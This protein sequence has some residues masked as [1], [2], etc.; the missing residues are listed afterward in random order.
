MKT[1]QMADFRGYLLLVP[2]AGGTT[3][4]TTLTL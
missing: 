2:T 3:V 1:Q 4:G